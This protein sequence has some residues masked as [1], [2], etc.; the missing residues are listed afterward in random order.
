MSKTSAPSKAA[1]A[2]LLA[3]AM[4]GCSYDVDYGP[5]LFETHKGYFAYAFGP[6]A[7]YTKKDTPAVIDEPSSGYREYRIDYQDLR[8]KRAVCWRTSGTRPEAEQNVVV[9]EDL[10]DNVERLIN[11]EVGTYFPTDAGWASLPLYESTRD[12]EGIKLE[13]YIG[14][15]NEGCAGSYFT[16]LELEAPGELY[17]LD[18]EDPVRR[19][20][21]AAF[22]DPTTGFS[23][24]DFPN[25]QTMSQQWRFDFVLT[26]AASIRSRETSEAEIAEITTK[27]MNDAQAYAEGFEAEHGYAPILHVVLYHEDI[28]TESQ[29]KSSTR[30]EA[31]WSD[32]YTWAE[33]E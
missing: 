30:Y 22:L 6:G 28:G 15:E 7:S 9:Y 24:I 1:I 25:L 33:I 11:Q 26:A 5:D 19:A 27:M 4:T 14:Q 17:L 8:A 13:P 29:P 20:E 16:L 3:T 31:R 21:A 23:F 18:S 2:L 12:V 10:L 32:G